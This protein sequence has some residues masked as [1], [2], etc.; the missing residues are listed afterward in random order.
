MLALFLIRKISQ[1]FSVVR[2]LVLPSTPAPSVLAY[3][4]CGYSLCG[5]P[6]PSITSNKDSAFCTVASRCSRRRGRCRMRTHPDRER[7]NARR[8]RLAR[9]RLRRDFPLSPSPRGRRGRCQLSMHEE[10]W[11]RGSG[12]RGTVLVVGFHPPSVH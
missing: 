5:S 10:G 1:N 7:P 3:V 6:L 4:I 2:L 9:R 11:L 8:K 12:C